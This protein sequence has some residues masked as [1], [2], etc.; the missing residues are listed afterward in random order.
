[1]LINKS[2]KLALIHT[3]KRDRGLDDEC[4]R[5]LL[6][7]CAGMDSAA[8][9]TTEKQFEDIMAAFKKLGF[10][11]QKPAGRTRPQW[12]DT[13][14]CTEDQRAKIEVMWKS[15]ARNPTER[16]LQVFIKRITKAES[17]HWLTADLAQKVIIALEKMR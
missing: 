11:Y 13:W 9:I 2:Q 16:A 14:A 6:Q 10:V 15:T 17:P 4:Y 12:A 1:M 8:D 3:A 5:L 7:S